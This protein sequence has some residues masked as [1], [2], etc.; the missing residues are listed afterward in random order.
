VE[1]DKS[2]ARSKASCEKSAD[3]NAGVQTFIGITEN[4]LM[5]VRF[6]RDDLME[7]ILS[8][9]NLNRA[10]KQVVSNKGSG[11]VDAMQVG[12]HKEKN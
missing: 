10:Y 2:E 7:Q 11:G 9:A 6:T 5:D 4:N 1:V 12:S 8:P 3:G